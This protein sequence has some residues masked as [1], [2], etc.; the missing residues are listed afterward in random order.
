[1]DKI[2]TLIKNTEKFLIECMPKFVFAVFIVLLFYY[3][4]KKIKIFS[5]KFYSKIFK[6]K[7]ELANLIGYIMY[8]LILFFGIFLSL[9]LLGLESVLVKMIA[10]AG[11]VGIVV[12]FAFKEIASNFLAGFFISI[13]KPF[14][15]GDWVEINGEYGKIIEM[16]S[17]TTSIKTPDG[18]NVYVPNHIIYQNIFTNFSTYSRR[19]VLLET[20]VSYGDDLEHVKFV[21]LDEVKKIKLLIDSEDIDFYYTSIGSS[22]FNFEVRFWIEFKEQTDY[23]E[24]MSELIIRIKKRFERE[25][26][27]IAYSVTTL[28]FDVKGGTN[29][30]DKAI[31]IDMNQS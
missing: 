8:F 3:L 17:M 25:K 15:I 28:D 31:K 21:T 24:A 16:G 9:E 18:Q 30:F 27:S 1:M 13:Q 4:A 6:T 12:G 2:E 23:L 10:S 5:I 14:K 7:K 29:I 11:V 26:I 22:T 20:G 19:R